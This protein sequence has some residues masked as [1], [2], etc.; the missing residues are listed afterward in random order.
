MCISSSSA[1]HY[2]D[3]SNC[4]TSNNS[5]RGSGYTCNLSNDS[6]STF[7]VYRANQNF[8]T[9][10]DI[11]KLFSKNNSEELL[12]INNLASSSQLLKPGKEVLLPVT[13]SCSVDQF[14]QVNL[15]Y[16]TPERT[17][18]SEVA[19][20]VFE[21]LLKN[22]TLVEE[23]LPLVN[24]LEAG[25]VLHVPLR[26]ACLDNFTSGKGVKYL[27]TYPIMKGDEPAKLCQK[28]RISSE[29]FWAV[30]TLT[31]WDSLFPDT[32]VL[33]PLTDTTIRIYD[34]PDSPPPASE[35]PS[36]I[37]GE[38]KQEAT[39]PVQLY[40]VGSIIGLLLLLTLMLAC[41]IYMK[42]LRRWKRENLMAF[43]V[44]NSPNSSSPT[45]SSPRST[46]TGR[47]SS[48]SCLSP[49]LLVGIKYCLFNYS[50][51][52]LKRATKDFSEENKIG[53]STYKGLVNDI[54]V[55]IK[56]VRFE[57]TRPVID[58]HSK[59]NHINIVSLQG[60][61]YGEGD[62]SW[63]YLVF[64]LPE[65]GN[66]RDCLSDLCNPL[67]WQR[68]T[69][70]A[71]DIATGL[72]YLHCCASPSYTHMNISSRIIFIT[73]NW[74]AK[75]ADIGMASA[76]IEKPVKG[77]DRTENHKGWVAPEYLL[78]G[79]V[80]EKVDIFAFGVVLLELISARDNIGEKSFKDSI[81]FLGSANERGCFEGLRGLMDPNLNDYPL[82][83]ALCLAVLAKACLADDP[84]H[85]PT[86]DDIMKVLG[87]VA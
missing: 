24:N 17:T 66:L 79:S 60:V 23:N 62:F 65:N 21:G 34:V 57:D 46:Q 83:E 48:T 82:A 6:C 75:L 4:S 49:D 54:E 8:Q 20:G 69:Q 29:D 45:R 85:R 18:F 47:T 52:E 37:P 63:S 86:M 58:L 50:L 1:Q 80:C 64:E 74:R 2:Y 15:T 22:H 35:F 7:L 72:H 14:Y 25:S 28:F 56:K 40:I 87:R 43:T 53:G 19:C 38:R 36:T 61:C 42:G 32:T 73:G 26:C 51:E 16:K 12:H 41:G 59:I 81:G 31:H 13:C 77:N 30:N 76:E 5:N 10:S 11:S 55:M 84:Q 78:H 33:I 3:S 44:T 9:I 39:K 68:R 71:F 67:H 70:I 27:V